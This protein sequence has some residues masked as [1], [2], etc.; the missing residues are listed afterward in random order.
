[1]NDICDNKDDFSTNFGLNTT[2]FQKENLTMTTEQNKAIV[3]RFYS[4]F[5]TNDQAVLNEVLSP[6]LVAITHGSPAL[7]SREQMLQAVSMWHATFSDVRFEILEQIAE[8][9]KVATRL[10]FQSTHSRGDFQG[11]APTGK[12]IETGSITIEQIKDGKIVWRVVQTDWK[13]IMQQLELNP[14]SQSAG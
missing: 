4:A 9:D 6:D 13:G 3:R 11:L 12:Q 2:E 14:H 1:V 10:T 7:Q 8:G 5:E